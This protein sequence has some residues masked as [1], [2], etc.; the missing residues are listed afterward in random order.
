MAAP[1]LSR[2]TR[3]NL[4]AP[5]FAG[6]LLI[7]IAFIAVV[8]WYLGWGTLLAPW[9]AL[10]W[11]GLAVAAALLLVSY[12][13][14]AL[15][16]YHYFQ[17]QMHGRFRHCMKLMLQHNLFN[18]LLPMRSGELSFPVLMA[19]YFDI[20]LL[21]SMAALLWFR[22]MDLHT[23]LA[24]ALAAAAGLWLDTTL[25]LVLFTVWMTLPWLCFRASGYLLQRIQQ[26]PLTRMTELGQRLLTGFPTTPAAFRRAWAWTVANWAVKLAV[27]VW[28]L[29]QFAAVATDTALLGVIAADLTSVLPVHGVAGAGTYEAGA[30]AVLVPGGLS[31]ATAL[32]AA[33]NLHLF[34]LGGAVLGGAASLMINGGRR[35]G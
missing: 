14:R 29:R 25:T 17:H 26:R 6:A 22:L 21:N 16:F 31:T 1:P 30:L 12:W 2:N 24:A 23:L 18:N 15:R 35:H 11:D 10:S 20:P 32:G 8:Q 19:R 13:L 33:V 4:L 27:L 3:H 7:L 5:R 9:R 34:V 28:V